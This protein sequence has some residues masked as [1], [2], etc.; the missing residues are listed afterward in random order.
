MGRVFANTVE[1]FKS[2]TS[3]VEAELA[4]LVPSF[5]KI[6]RRPT[7]SLHSIIDK[8]FQRKNK[9]LHELKERFQ[10]SR[11]FHEHNFTKSLWN[12]YHKDRTFTYRHMWNVEC[13]RSLHGSRFSYRTRNSS[14]GPNALF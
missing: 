7:N 14:L 3:Q 6:D 10:K 8:M 13:D 9:T 5:V 4:K 1:T 2:D 11:I 12:Y